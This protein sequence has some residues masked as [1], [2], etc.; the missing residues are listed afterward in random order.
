LGAVTVRRHLGDWG[1]VLAA[2]GAMLQ[3]MSDIAV[4]KL[5]AGHG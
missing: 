2:T 1:R 5:L 3:G 4:I